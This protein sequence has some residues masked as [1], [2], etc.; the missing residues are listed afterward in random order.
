MLV[1]DQR[2]SQT[3]SLDMLDKRQIRIT[4]AELVFTNSP[5]S[6]SSLASDEVLVSLRY[7]RVAA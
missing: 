2:P 1:Y 5:F 7:C 4:D 6:P 3:P